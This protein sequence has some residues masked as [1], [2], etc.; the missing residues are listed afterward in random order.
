MRAACVASALG[1]LLACASAG[2]ADE[3]RNWFDDPF[4][5]LVAEDPRCPPPAGPFVTEQERRLQSHR[6]A[7]KGTT[8]WLA[9]EADRPRAYAYDADIAAALAQAFHSDARFAGSALWATVQG[10]VV[11]IEGCLSGRTGAAQL[12]AK[13]RALPHVQQAIA[14]V[15]TDARAKPPYRVMPPPTA[16]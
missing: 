16:R 4:L 5:Q 13:V 2:A 3:L 9:G 8:A 10:R 7:E 6:R 11:F 14:I 15:R 12:E 1:G